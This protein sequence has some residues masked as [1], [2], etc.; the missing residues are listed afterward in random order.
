VTIGLK[1][2]EAMLPARFLP[3]PKEGSYGI[4]DPT[5]KLVSR[6][7]D[8]SREL[9]TAGWMSSRFPAKKGKQ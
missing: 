5:Y 2:V 8:P 4:L 9:F 1:K 7:E 6:L 3:N